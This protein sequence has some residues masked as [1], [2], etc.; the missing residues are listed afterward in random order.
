MERDRE[1][2]WHSGASR[3]FEFHE[4]V[5][6]P[7]NRDPCLNLPDHVSASANYVS[8]S[9]FPSATYKTAESPTPPPHNASTKKTSPLLFYEPPPS[10][11]LIISTSSNDNPVATIKSESPGQCSQVR[12]GQTETKP[13]GSCSTS[14][15][16]S[17]SPVS[18]S[19]CKSVSQN[20]I[21]VRVP[22][23]E[24]ADR[25]S[26]ERLIS[27]RG[28]ENGEN[29]LECSDVSL[30]TDLSSP[31]S[32]DTKVSECGVCG[33]EK[34]IWVPSISE[35]GEPLI[36]STSGHG[37]TI[38]IDPVD[39]FWIQCDCC[40]KWFHGSCVGV[41][42]YEDALIDKF[43]C[44]SCSVENGPTKMREV[45]LRHRFAFD[46]MSQAKLP[47]EIGT[48]VWIKKFVETE[49]RNPTS[50]V[51]FTNGPCGSDEAGETAERYEPLA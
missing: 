15:P 36:E 40:E 41:E 29:H 8:S 13:I 1:V 33:P 28:A 37:Q 19:P 3:Q 34:A 51:R 27:I 12:R 18:L 42:E 17:K 48:E 2:S 24:A 43:H 44:Q 26:S 16:S 5:P 47:P 11:P 31:L 35:T 4:F 20:P 39:T 50:Y 38:K 10:G 30:P 49:G 9:K 23:Y 25:S 45:L 14:L 22:T 32:V 21:E 46:D 7:S 6:G